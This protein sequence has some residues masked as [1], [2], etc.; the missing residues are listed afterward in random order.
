MNWAKSILTRLSLFEG[1]RRRQRQRLVIRPA[2]VAT[3]AIGDIH[4]CMDLLLDLEARIFTD[5]EQFVGEKLIVVLGDFV[6]RG[7]NSADV[8]DHLLAPPPQGFARICIC[9]NHEDRMSRALKDPALVRGWL[10]M[11]GQETL[12]AYGIRP[13]PVT[14]FDMPKKRIHLMLKSHIPDAHMDFLAGLP[15]SVEM[16]EVFFVH[17]GID[18]SRSIADQRQQDL[19]WIRKPFVDFE[20]KFE[21]IIV[22]GHTPGEA[23]PIRSNRIAVDTGA[24]LSGVLSAVRIAPGYGRKII[25]TDGMSA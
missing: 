12:H 16:D 25:R 10:K 6:D 22:H 11:G 21:K 1:D 5:S 24:Y 7:P 15:C 3:Y 18:P 23:D 4:G 9:G 14:G 19:L 13:D 20:G 2:P 17:A 8:L